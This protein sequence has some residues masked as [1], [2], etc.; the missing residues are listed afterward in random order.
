[1]I[2]VMRGALDKRA[3]DSEDGKATPPSPPAADDGAPAGG[4]G[5]GLVRAPLGLQPLLNAANVA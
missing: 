4:L 1:M 3:Q 5:G 2:S